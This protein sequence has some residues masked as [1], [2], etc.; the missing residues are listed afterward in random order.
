MNNKQ[1]IN[2]FRSICSFFFTIEAIVVKKLKNKKQWNHAS[3]QS[4]W[5]KKEA[6]YLRSH[7]SYLFAIVSSFVF[8]YL[9]RV[10]LTENAKEECYLYLWVFSYIRILQLYLYVFIIIIHLVLIYLSAAQILQSY[11]VRAVKSGENRS[12]SA[13]LSP[14]SVQIFWVIL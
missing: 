10:F 4:F 6:E 11:G 9:V 3:I 14:H 5:C 2:K 7:L 8:F 12:A 13:P 1:F